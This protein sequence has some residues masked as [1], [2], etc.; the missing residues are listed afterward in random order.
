MLK[1][2]ENVKYDGKLGYYRPKLLSD[3]IAFPSKKIAVKFAK[4]NS[5]PL[6]CI[7]KVGSRFQ[8]AWG[9]K[10]DHNRFLASGSHN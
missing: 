3:L 10:D 9:F 1:W 8:S 2:I 5:I 7:V 6:V 4:A